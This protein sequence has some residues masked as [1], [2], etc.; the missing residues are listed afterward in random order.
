[1][2]L[3]PEPGI[4]KLIVS[5]PALLFASVMAWRSEPA[6]ESFVLITVKVAALA[7]LS[8]QPATSAARSVRL[9]PSS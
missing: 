9:I 2:V 1:M 5:V 7:I 3:W 8:P 6:P 4:L